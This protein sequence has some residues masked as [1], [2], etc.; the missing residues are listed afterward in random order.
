M[1]GSEVTREQ[2]NL[3]RLVT[4]QAMRGNHPVSSFVTRDTRDLRVVVLVP[5]IGYVNVEE[6]RTDRA[7]AAQ[8]RHKSLDTLLGRRRHR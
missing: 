2:V 5:P 8:E 4:V 6:G 1:S 7:P 3:H